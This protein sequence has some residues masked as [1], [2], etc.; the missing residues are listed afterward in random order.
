MRT[1]LAEAVDS[2]ESARQEL[3]AV[4]G[5]RAESAVLPAGLVSN[6]EVAVGGTMLASSGESFSELFD[7]MGSAEDTAGLRAVGNDAES[8]GA[9]IAAVLDGFGSTT[10]EYEQLT[11]YV[12]LAA[13]I[14]GL[15]AIDAGHLQDWSEVRSRI[16]QSLAPA[17]LAEAS[18]G[19]SAD[20]ALDH[21][22]GLVGQAQERLRA[23]RADYDAAADPS[24][25]RSAPLTTYR[26]AMTTQLDRYSELRG[27]LSDWIDRVEDPPPPSPTT[28]G[29]TS[30]GA[31]R[32]TVR[33]SATPCP[34]LRS[35][36]S[37]RTSHNDW[38]RCLTTESQR[39]PRP[40]KGSWTRTS[41]PSGATTRTR[42]AGRGS[43]PS[44]PGSPTRSAWRSSSGRASWATPRRLPRTRVSATQPAGLSGRPHPPDST[45]SPTSCARPCTPESGQR[46]LT[47]MSRF[48]VARGRARA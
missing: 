47:R 22:N 17:E 26:D 19:S 24:A 14:A 31:P 34:S 1:T 45:S 9:G 41:A 32:W 8:L 5:E 18:L 42:P 23:W 15:S 37:S 4:D 46:E 38:S 30:C 28:K 39:S 6:V 44:R 43:A 27:S 13:A 33:T 21:V 3:R 35:R 29:T 20:T 12:D 36:P 16:T 7:S 2:Y 11:A 25:T 10:D 40:T 48:R